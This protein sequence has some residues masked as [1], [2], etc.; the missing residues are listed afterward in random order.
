MSLP[1]VNESPFEQITT[2]LMPKSE[3]ASL[4]LFAKL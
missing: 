3:A 2:A 4:I 1:A